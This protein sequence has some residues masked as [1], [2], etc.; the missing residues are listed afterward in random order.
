M[1]AELGGVLCHLP[2]LSQAVKPCDVFH[3][4]RFSHAHIVIGRRRWPS[5]T[6]PAEPDEICGRDL[7]QSASLRSLSRTMLSV[8][9]F[10]PACYDL[11]LL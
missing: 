2:D 8:Q 9:L 6:P 3:G 10:L 1:P 11:R 5:R 7:L 4:V